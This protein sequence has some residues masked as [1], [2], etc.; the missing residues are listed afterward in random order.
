MTTHDYTYKTFPDVFLATKAGIFS[1][2]IVFL[3]NPK[4]VFFYA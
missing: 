2:S 3:P 1:H 4:Q